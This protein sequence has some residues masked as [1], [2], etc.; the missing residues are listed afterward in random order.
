MSNLRLVIIFLGVV[1]IL[2]LGLI[3]W[4]LSNDKNIP[5]VF[6]GTVGAALGG[7]T[8]ILARPEGAAA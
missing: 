2:C 3:A 5:D 7:L 6:V 1:T 8:G 4:L